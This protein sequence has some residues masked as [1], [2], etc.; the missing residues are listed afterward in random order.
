MLDCE[1]ALPWK[2]L[3]VLLSSLY[4]SQR[5]LVSVKVKHYCVGTVPLV[6]PCFHPLDYHGAGSLKARERFMSGSHILAGSNKFYIYLGFFPGPVEGRYDA[7]THS[8]S[9][10]PLAYPW[11]SSFHP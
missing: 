5:Y 6:L 9:L 10:V 11:N 7:E 1:V 2:I 3:S 4:L 8:V